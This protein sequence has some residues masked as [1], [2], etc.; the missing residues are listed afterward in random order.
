MARSEFVSAAGKVFEFV[1]GIAQEV[2][3]LGG[4]DEDLGRVLSE[5]ALRRQIAQLILGNHKEQKE[6]L[7]LVSINY[8][9]SV[10]AMVRAGDYD[11]QNSDITER[12]FPSEEKGTRELE[13]HLVHFNRVMSS[14]D[15]KRELAKLGLRPATLKELLAFGA[16][17]KEEQRKYPIVALGSVW[18]Y[19]DG[20]RDVPYLVGYSGYRDLNLRWDDADWFELYR[21]LAVS[22]SA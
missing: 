10:E 2:Q 17:Y 11:Y 6:N 3:D 8:D 12:N 5:K 22:K 15:V 9:L 19:W 21:F 16:L 13:L 14:D 18:Q 7:F 4:N 1:K 20:N